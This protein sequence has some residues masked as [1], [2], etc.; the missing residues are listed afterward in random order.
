MRPRTV[1]T[2]RTLLIV[3]AL[4]LLLSL[5]PAGLLAQAPEGAGGLTPVSAGGRTLPANVPQELQDALRAGMTPEEFVDLLGYTPRALQDVMD[6]E[7]LVIIQMDREPAAR[8][9]AAARVSGEP[10]AQDAL[11]GYRRALD[12][13]QTEMMAR[14]SAL[15]AREI[16]RYNTV[17]N[18]VQ[19]LVPA[20]AIS[21]IASLPGVISVRR[22]PIH[23]PTLATSVP[24]IGA[25]ALD[26]GLGLRGEGLVIAVIDTGIDY[27]HAA[28]GGSGDPADYAA[29]NPAIIE[30]GTFPTAKVIGGY[31]FAGSDYNAGG[32]AVIPQPD[33]DPLDENGHGSHVSST[34]AGAGSTSIGEGVAPDAQL[35]AYKVF[36]RSGSTSLVVDAL[37][38]ATISYLMYGYPH[39]INM[40]LGSPFGAADPLDADV[41]ASDAASA[42]GIVVVASA[43]NEGD[44]TYITGSPGV[45]SSA[46][47]VAATTTG[48]ITGPTVSLP[49]TP[50]FS[51]VVY[52]PP[53]FE[54][55]TGQF[56]SAVNAPLTNVAGLSGASDN[57]MCTT[58]NI[59]VG[60]LTGQVALISRG[61]CDFFMKV[62]NAASLG[63]VGALIYNNAAGGEEFINMSGAMV[64]IPAGFLRHSDGLA[65]VA[66]SGQMGLVSDIHTVQ[67]VLD[68]VIPE[69]S[70]ASFSSAGPRGY[71]SMLK[72]DIAAPGVGIFAADMG[73]G[74][75][76]VSMGGTSMAAPHVAGV[77]ALVLQAHPEWTPEMVKAAIMNT[78]VDVADD[79]RAPRV[80]AGRVD[81]LHAATTPIIAVADESL[82]SL[83]WGVVY[84]KESSETLSGEITVTSVAPITSTSSLMVVSDVALALLSLA[85]GVD[86]MRVSPATAELDPGES[87]T[88]TVEIDLDMTAVAN[89]VNRTA[90]ESY[91]GS[92]SFAYGQ[93]GTV[94]DPD[95]AIRLPF[96]FAPRPYNSLALTGDG[97]IV[98]PLTDWATI[99]ISQTGSTI[100]DLWAYPALQ[101][102]DQASAGIQASASI[103]ALG[104][105]YAG[106]D[107]NY[108]DLIGVAINTWEPP[109]VPQPS[110]AEFDLY[111]D[112]DD[113]GVWDFIDF[114]VDLG[115]FDDAPDNVWLVAQYETATGMI[116]QGGFVYYADFNSSLLE[117]WLPAVWHGLDSDASALTYQM[118]SWDRYGA[119]EAS[120]VGYFD[121]M[122]PPLVWNY[123]TS[124]AY[125]WLVSPTSP[126]TSAYTWPIDV[127]AYNRAEPAG[128]MILD[129]YGDPRNQ[130]GAQAYFAPI[131]VVYRYFNW[132]PF[133]MK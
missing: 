107:P 66:H 54:G 68:E 30:P 25:E 130:D 42:A 22:A 8:A 6:R 94:F 15:G 7:V 44:V 72:P 80:G 16:S 45:A 74:E 128:L 57:L 33:R 121:Y 92:V 117:W 132:M 73:A 26:T 115:W 1:N 123:A 109:H 5:L 48:S 64:S 122:T 113:D 112:V 99:D 32:T 43:G 97:E 85:D 9:Y 69:D 124:P 103:R 84:S 55:G 126:D 101:A 50:A 4:A 125:P 40:S 21:E 87:A 53:A 71:D 100:S 89:D 46:I 98:D 91:F 77:A 116:Y 39:V 93:A 3:I 47:A 10:M 118:V 129:Y 13:E 78:G 114:N 11:D 28:L 105:D 27:N 95:G 90:L 12:G 35:I 67:T 83:N 29:N 79:N 60:S 65:L 19:A 62:H 96:H 81:A 110:V 20:R 59:P 133:V 127:A 111:L 108:G 56:A 131:D 119:Y 24:L 14:A 61:S 38:M 75:G 52:Q 104:M 41:A 86:D 36:G 17:Y 58:N 2:R 88:F 106:A 51:P 63:A 102:T 34:A 76:G 120:P 37:E 18:G 82:V 70:V 31:D 23:T 49:G